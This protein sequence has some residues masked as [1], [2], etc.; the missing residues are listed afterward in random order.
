[1]KKKV[2]IIL[3]LIAVICSQIPVYAKD[4]NLWE[5]QLYG[6]YVKMD[7]VYDLNELYQENP[8]MARKEAAQFLIERAGNY[9]SDIYKQSEMLT[10]EICGYVIDEEGYGDFQIGRASCRERV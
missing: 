4:E 3:T 9:R 10:L 1:M 6:W 2:C 7:D 5:M 8:H